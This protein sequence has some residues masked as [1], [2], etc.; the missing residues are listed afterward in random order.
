MVGVVPKF[1][2]KTKIVVPSLDILTRSI[3]TAPSWAR[4]P[5]EASATAA[6]ARKTAPRRPIVRFRGADTL[7]EFARGA[8]RFYQLCLVVN[9][10]W[11][12][13]CSDY[14]RGSSS[15]PSDETA[16]N[17]A[18]TRMKASTTS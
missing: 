4:R 12:C 11:A 18:D 15:R 5:L 3:T 6:A 1:R 8:Q 17:D 2:P 10:F 7:R 14:T 9:R 13:Q 16:S